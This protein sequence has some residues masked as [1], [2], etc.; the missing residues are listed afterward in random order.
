MNKEQLEM[1]LEG[2]IATAVEKTCVLGEEEAKADVSKIIEMIEE[3]ES[4]WNPDG[5][6]TNVDY[7]LKANEV[8]ARIK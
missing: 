2:L 8:L 4:F 3:L 7:V 5:E 1:M 6:V